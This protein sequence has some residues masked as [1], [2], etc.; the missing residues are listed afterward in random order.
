[1]TTEFDKN[2]ILYGPPGTG[3]TYNTAIYAVAI[4]TGRTISDVASEPYS[5]IMDTYDRLKKENRVAFTTFHQSYGYEEFIEGIKPV[6]DQTKNEIGYTVEPGVFK[7]FC[8]DARS[9]DSNET[10]T[11]INAH[12]QIWKLT[13]MS[14]EMNQIKQLGQ[15]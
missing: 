7:K 1:M 8:D 2:I 4:C 13:I 12:A 3:K 5:H 10:G 11:L 9:I 15:Q 6:V 14:G